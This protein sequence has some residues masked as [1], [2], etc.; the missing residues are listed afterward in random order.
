MTDTRPPRPWLV[1][2]LPDPPVLT[3]AQIAKLYEQE[4]QWRKLF[5]DKVRE[6]EVGR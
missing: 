5:E 4:R 3:D 6:M 2:D 1:T